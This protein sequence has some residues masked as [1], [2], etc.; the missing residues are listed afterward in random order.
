NKDVI[1]R[2]CGDAF[3]E[4]IIVLHCGVDTEVFQQRQLANHPN[5]PLNIVCIG[6]L[7]EVKGQTHLLS[8][9]RILRDHGLSFTCTLIG[10]GPDLDALQA[11]VQRDGLEAYVHFAGRKTH[12]EV[13]AALREAD[14]V[15]APSVPSSDGRR[16]GIP[17]ALMEAMGSGVPV[18]ASDLSGIPELVIDEETGLLT[19][20]GD[21]GAIAAALERLYNDPELRQ[22]LG[23]AG[24]D[25]VLREFDLHKNAEHLVELFQAEVVLR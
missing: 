6:T 23:S 2:E 19:P 15:V 1:L 10:D 11:Q 18:V 22:R 8:A 3:A 14:V 25:K 12:A 16:E 9:C 20:P 21:A 7:H 24:R 5:T 13:A 17:V 4:K